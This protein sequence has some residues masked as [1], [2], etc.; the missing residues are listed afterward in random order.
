MKPDHDND[1]SSASAQPCATGELEQDRLLEYLEGGLSARDRRSMA[2][3]MAVCGQCKSVAAQW[4]ELDAGLANHFQP[5]RLPGD[6]SSRV[7]R[8]VDSL[9][10]P[11]PPAASAPSALDDTQWAAVWARQRRRLLWTHLPSA[12]DQ[13][14]YAFAIVLTLCFL[15]RLVPRLLSSWTWLSQAAPWQG[16]LAYGL[17]VSAPILLVALAFTAK[18]PL[19]RFLARL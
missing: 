15:S 6:F 13:F 19:A 5:H 11:V 7:W 4:T 18:R 16:L 8:A 10:S 12:L 17:A 9:S 1:D 3:H 2:A 14:G